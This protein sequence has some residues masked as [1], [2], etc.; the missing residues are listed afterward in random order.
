MASGEAAVPRPSPMR[1]SLM[2]IFFLSGFWS[3]FF[4]ACFFASL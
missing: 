3:P 1:V 4:A 2:S